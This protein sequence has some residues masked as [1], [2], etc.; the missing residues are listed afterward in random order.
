M[1]FVDR[2]EVKL[3]EFERKGAT[4]TPFESSMIEEIRKMI[5]DEKRP[6]V[7]LNPSGGRRT[8]R[9]SRASQRR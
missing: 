3:R 7:F 5:E 1:D 6:N 4:L 8:R 9:R 2:L